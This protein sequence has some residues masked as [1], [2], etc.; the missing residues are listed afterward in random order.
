MIKQ[1]ILCGKSPEVAKR[2]ARRLAQRVEEQYLYK[3]PTLLQRIN[4]IR[5]GIES[6][7][8]L[9]HSPAAWARGKIGKVF[10]KG[11]AKLGGRV[12]AIAGLAGDIIEIGKACWHGWKAHQ[13][14]KGV[15][16]QYRECATRQKELEDFRGSL[17]DDERTRIE[18]L[19]RRER[20]YYLRARNEY[21]RLSTEHGEEPEYLDLRNLN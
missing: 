15:K 21:Q 10:T 6:L 4:P 18:D 17:T 20:E 3:N 11:L 13:S 12:F 7:R 1:L 2:M 19:Y 14:W 9:Y 5:R 8:K 16:A